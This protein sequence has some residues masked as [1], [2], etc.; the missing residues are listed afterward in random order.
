[1]SKKRINLTDEELSFIEIALNEQIKLWERYLKEGVEPTGDW[2]K[3]IAEA[4]ALKDKVTKVFE[5]E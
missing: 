2:K 5:G 4:N 3:Y 1:M